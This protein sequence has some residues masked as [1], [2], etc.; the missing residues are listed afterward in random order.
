M[1]LENEKLFVDEELDNELLFASDKTDNIE[2]AEPEKYWK[3]VIAD[4]EEEVH[5]MTRMV[6]KKFEF[7]GQKIEL[8]SSYSGKET[9][10]VMSDNPDVAILLLDVVMETENSGLEVVKAI[11]EELANPFVRII[12]RTGQPGQA[13]EEEVIRSYDIN[14]YKSK[15]ELTVQKLYTAVIASLR[16]YRDMKTIE[17]NRIGLEHIINSSRNLF[18]MQSLKAFTADVLDQFTNLLV[19][20]V[21]EESEIVGLAIT[22]IGGRNKIVESTLKYKSY[23]GMFIED[24][25]DLNIVKNINESFS[26]KKT[27]FA[28]NYYIGYFDSLKQVENLVYIESPKSFTE[29]EIDLIKIFSSNVAVAFDNIYLNNEIVDTQKEVIYTLGEIV[30]TR[31]KETANHVRRVSEYSYIIAKAVG[32]AN[33]EA[34]MLRLAS[35]M[36]DIGKIGIPDYI[37]NKPGKLTKEEFEVIKT[38]T[39]IGH[40]VLKQSSRK[41][42][43]TAATIALEHHERWDGNGYPNNIKGEEINI[44][45]RITSIADVY[46]ALGHKRVYKDAWS[47]DEIHDFLNEQKGKMFDPKVI[48]LFFENIDKIQ[49][50]KRRYPD[51]D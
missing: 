37:L 24:I 1:L 4:D 8:I 10:R 48:D 25:D 35:P 45:A 12:L 18:E 32:L 28:S 29:L 43:K 51:A 46:D 39:T 15:T 41:I 17:R 27:S 14:D 50:I 34:K 3:I 42:M 23:V 11:R 21:T 20:D 38:H 36:H 6:L 13:P 22:S 19:N 7:E 33:D 9:I 31:S 2:D 30:E 47:E 44:Y 26:N 49:D 5:A 40:E 16:A